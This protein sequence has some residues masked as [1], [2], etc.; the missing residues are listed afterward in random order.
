MSFFYLG[1]SWYNVGL[2]L[3]TCFGSDVA[4]FLFL[5]VLWP[6][7]NISCSL[8]RCSFTT[9]T[10]TTA[11]YSQ[12]LPRPHF[13]I[14]CFAVEWV[15]D[16]VSFVRVIMPLFSFCLASTVIVCPSDFFFVFFL[17]FCVVYSPFIF[18]WAYHNP[19]P[20]KDVR[21]IALSGEFGCKVLNEHIFVQNT[22]VLRAAPCPSL[23]SVFGVR[24]P[25]CKTFIMVFVSL[26]AQLR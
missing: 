23:L 26:S 25:L 18:S 14:V 20:G 5:L 10:L 9:N 2:L 4:D 1:G 6:P 11:T 16:N 3:S 21:H 7:A 12:N 17:T 13:R 8:S 19:V 15:V 24:K 22:T